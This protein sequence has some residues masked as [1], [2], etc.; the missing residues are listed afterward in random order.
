MKAKLKFAGIVLLIFLLVNTLFEALIALIERYYP[1]S[2]YGIFPFTRIGLL[3]LTILAV[4]A[5]RSPRAKRK[6][7]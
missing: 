3:V 6:T 7:A 4:R 2:L 1:V 5:L